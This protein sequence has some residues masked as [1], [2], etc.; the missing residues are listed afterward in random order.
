LTGREETVRTADNADIVDALI[1][2]HQA[3]LKK[4]REAKLQQAAAEQAPVADRDPGW[5]F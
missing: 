4:H 3:R 2:I 1:G 5:E